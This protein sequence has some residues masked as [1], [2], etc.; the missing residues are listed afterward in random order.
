MKYADDGWDGAIVHLN[1]KDIHN[2][3]GNEEEINIMT[4]VL[5][6]LIGGEI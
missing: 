2:D 4:Q 3:G 6:S 5:T 1:L